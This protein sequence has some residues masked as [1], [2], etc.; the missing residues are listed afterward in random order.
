VS[1]RVDS[2]Q[3]AARYRIKRAD[4]FM[5]AN[6]GP[7]GVMTKTWPTGVMMV[8]V[9]VLLVGYLMLYYVQ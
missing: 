1:P 7:Y 8:W 2:V 4:R 9:A 5:R 6:K 3:R